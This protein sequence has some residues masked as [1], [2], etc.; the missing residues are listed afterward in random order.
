MMSVIITS[1]TPLFN[2]GINRVGML[3]AIYVYNRSGD[4]RP[5]FGKCYTE[6][7]I[8]ELHRHPIGVG[9]SA[10]LEDLCSLSYTHHHHRQGKAS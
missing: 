2:L 10:G 5:N 9:G 8:S 1:T 7:R 3:Q 4:R 6:E